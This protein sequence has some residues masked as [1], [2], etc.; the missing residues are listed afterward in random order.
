MSRLA[1]TAFFTLAVLHLAAAA[2]VAG[3]PALPDPHPPL[4]A[5][6]A[7]SADDA[8][9]DRRA[10]GGSANTSTSLLDVVS[11]AV[12]KLSQASVAKTAGLST[13]RKSYSALIAFGASYTGESRQ[14]APGGRAR[15][16]TWGTTF[17]SAPLT[18][19]RSAVK[20]C[21]LTNLDWL[22]A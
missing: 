5:R 8:V 22:W 15:S 7:Y 16:E 14:G 11:A 20:T 4:D 1:C 21:V 2:P 17:S 18:R 10:D 19:A 9:L 12:I 13:T 3:G 6:R